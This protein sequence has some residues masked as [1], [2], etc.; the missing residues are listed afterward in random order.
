MAGKRIDHVGVMVKNIEKSIEFYTN[1]VGMELKAEVPHSNGV[2]K[3]AFLGFTGNEETELELIQGYNDHLPEEGTVHHFA[4][5]TDDVEGE[6]TRLKELGIEL[7]DQEIT[8]LPNG[9]KYFFFY[10]PDREWIEFFQR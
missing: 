3:L 5:S 6:F 9:Y 1:A 7:I 8:T 2:I 4:V 10:G